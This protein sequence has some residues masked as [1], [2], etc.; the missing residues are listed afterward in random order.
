MENSFELTLIKTKSYKLIPFGR[1][2][3]CFKETKRTKRNDVI[4][5]SELDIYH[6]TGMPYT[7]EQSK[8]IIKL[9]KKYKTDVLTDEHMS[10]FYTRGSQFVEIRHT[11]L[12]SYRF[13]LRDNGWDDTEATWL[14]YVDK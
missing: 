3:I 5:M 8:L 6:D 14:S 9:M 13:Y 1:F 2:S 7:P 4:L 11:K 10:K 12:A